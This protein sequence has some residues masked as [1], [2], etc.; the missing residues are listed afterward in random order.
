SGFRPLRPSPGLLAVEP[1]Q[2]SFRPLEYVSPSGRQILASPVDVKV[3]ERYRRPEGARFAAVAML[4]R[5]LERTR[6]RI[7]IVPPEYPSRDRHS[8]AM[9][10][11]RCGP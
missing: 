5:P 7:R 2:C 1:A 10:G 4:R 9:S 3:Q 8:V 11:D 6:D